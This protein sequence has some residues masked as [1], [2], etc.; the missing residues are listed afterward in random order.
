MIDNDKNK[1]FKNFAV[2]AFQKYILKQNVEF[3]FEA[4]KNLKNVKVYQM[5]NFI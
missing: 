5:K 4:L 3:F 2:C 1:N